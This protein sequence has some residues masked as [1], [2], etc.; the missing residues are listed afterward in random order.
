M[1][2]RRILLVDDE[3]NFRRSLALMLHQAGYEVDGL[4]DGQEALRRLGGE[5]Y[6]LIIT[7]L[8]MPGID[9]MALLEE[10]KRIHPETLVVMMSAYGSS[11]LALE[12]VKRGA[13]DYIAK[14]F[15]SDELLLLL[16][17]AEERERL[18]RENVRL[19]REVEGR[20]GGG[21]LIARSP[22]MLEVMRTAGKVAD[23]KTT[24]LITGESGTGKEM[25]ARAIHEMSLR[26]EGPLVSLNCGAIPE[27]L[28]ESELFGYVRGAFT[29][30]GRNKRGLFEE[31]DGG[32]L[33]LDEIG[34]LPQ[35]LQV[36]LLRA[37]Q[38]GEVR[39][40]GDVRS[41]PVNVRT[42]A[43]TSKDLEKELREGRFREDLFYRLDVVRIELPPLRDRRED[44]APLAEHFLQLHAQR[45]GRRVAAIAPEA[46]SALVQ[47]PWP[48]NVREL[49]NAI[50]RA[51]VLAENGRVEAS[52]LPPAFP[53]PRTEAAAP[54][55][56]IK[57]ATSR[58]EAELIRQALA[59]TQGNRTQAARLLEISHRALLYKLKHYGL[60]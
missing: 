45:L 28:L 9:G 2:G 21:S 39:R 30:A 38:E 13:I 31:S 24:V 37:L 49:E 57:R 8:R 6:D 29:D 18:R 58:I 14:P 55:L 19:R 51:V 36:K 4:G 3:E 15:S 48:G 11:D 5:I 34:D 12:A 7:D 25:V 33:F 47:A 60:D 50:E 54:E 17:K 44:I 43:A 46:M 40:L 1:R 27:N 53:T 35:P 10:V 52:L 42:I 22:A 32:T 23:H 56:S 59:R 20:H 26:R 41:I 16:R